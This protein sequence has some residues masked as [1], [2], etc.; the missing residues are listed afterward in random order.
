MNTVEET[1]KVFSLLPQ[2]MDNR[3]NSLLIKTYSSRVYHLSSEWSEFFATTTI[4]WLLHLLVILLMGAY[5][6]GE[7]CDELLTFF[8]TILLVW[9]IYSFIFRKYYNKKREIAQSCRFISNIMYML[10]ITDEQKMDILRETEK[11]LE[12]CNH[13]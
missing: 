13:F 4:W 3:E 7:K 2:V 6:H 12:L 11:V 8:G 10:I 5:Y 1:K 9:W